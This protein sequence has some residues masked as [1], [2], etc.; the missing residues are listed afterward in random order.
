MSLTPNI[1]Q[2]QH[3]A[4]EEYRVSLYDSGMQDPLKYGLSGTLRKSSEHTDT[5][6]NAR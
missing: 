3:I 2:L 1:E 4:G 6:L 5:L